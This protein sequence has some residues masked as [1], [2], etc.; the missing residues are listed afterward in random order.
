[1]SAPSP[2]VQALQQE[3]NRFAKDPTYGFDPIACDGLTGPATMQALIWALTAIED[4]SACSVAAS[5]P[6]DVASGQDLRSASAAANIDAINKPGDIPAL[7]ENLAA[8]L[9]E[10]AAYLKYPYAACAPAGGAVTGA[11]PPAR[12]RTPAAAAVAEKYKSKITGGIFGLGLPDWMVYGLGAT[13]A[14]G[15]GYLVMARPKRGGSAR[16]FR[17]HP[18]LI[19]RGDSTIVD[20]G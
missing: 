17:A 10:G 7:A 3:I 1:M 8:L 20:E 15:V 16:E 6:E 9:Q 5:C 18:R 14:L 12:P 13:L 19:A 2:A 4:S 11:S